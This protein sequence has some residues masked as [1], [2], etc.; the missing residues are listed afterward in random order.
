MSGPAWV[1]IPASAPGS[2]G[3]A[4]P[5]SLSVV[6]CTPCLVFG[7]L[8][9][10]CVAG[11]VQRP[12]GRVFP[13]HPAEQGALDPRRVLGY[14]LERDRVAQQVLVGLGLAAGLHQLEERRADVHCLAHGL[15]D[16]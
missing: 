5:A 3:P 16:K 7:D 2:A 4:S 10:A 14:A 6:M 1:A 12:G 8:A 15:A 9:I 13:G 11:P